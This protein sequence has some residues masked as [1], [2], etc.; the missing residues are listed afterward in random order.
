MNNHL[1]TFQA[2]PRGDVEINP[3]RS[4]FS[5]IVPE[6]SVNLCFDPELLGFGSGA[7]T[8]YDSLGFA[9][10]TAQSTYQRRG[11]F[12]A[13]VT[14]I[15]ERYDGIRYLL[16]LAPAIRTPYT[17]SV[18][19]L[20]IGDYLV[21]VRDTSTTKIVASFQFEG[22]TFWTRQSVTC[23]TQTAGQLALE[24]VVFPDNY[25]LLSYAPGF[26]VDGF[27]FEQKP[28]ATTFISGDVTGFPNERPRGYGWLGTPHNSASYRFVSTRSG[29]K[30]VPFDQMG[31][32]VLEFTGLGMPDPEHGLV[33][34]ALLHGAEYGCTRLP[35][36]EFSI[37]GQLSGA[38]PK[39]W[40]CDRQKMVSAFNPLKGLVRLQFQLFDCQTPL[41]E[42][43]DI[44]ALYQSGMDLRFSSHFGE[45]ISAS[46]VMPKPLIQSG[47]IQSSE[48]SIFDPPLELPGV[49]ARGAN[50]HWQFIL[51][52]DVN[53]P[54]RD[55]VIGPDG[56]LY[57]LFSVDIP[58]QTS[59]QRFDG[60]NWVEIAVIDGDAVRMAA[61][62]N[63]RLYI[64]GEFTGIVGLGIVLDS[65]V[66]YNIRS[67]TF[68]DMNSTT[69][70]GVNV[71]TLRCISYHKAGFLLVGGSFSSIDNTNSAPVSCSNV[72][73]YDIQTSTWSDMGGG[74]TGSSV[75]ALAVADNGL[76]FAGGRFTDGAM[77]NLAR[78]DP[79]TGLW[80]ETD[81][82][83]WDGDPLEATVYALAFAPNGRLYVGGRFND[84]ALH[85]YT[86]NGF[87]SGTPHPIC[88]I[89]YYDATGKTPT[90][91]AGLWP[92]GTGTDEDYTLGVPRE[93]AIYDIAV[94]CDG[95]VFV[96]GEF[97]YVYGPFSERGVPGSPRLTYFSPGLA[98]FSPD[99]RWRAPEVLMD[100]ENDTYV[101]VKAVEFGVNCQNQGNVA[102]FGSG[103]A[104]TSG[105]IGVPPGY[106][107]SL[108]V[109]WADVPGIA[110][111][112][113]LPATTVIN[114]GCSVD[115]R[116]VIRVVGPGSLHAITNYSTGERITF[117]PLI[118]QSEETIT[119]DLESPTPRIYSNVQGNVANYLVD[120]TQLSIFR[121]QP[122]NNYIQL[123]YN[124]L[125]GGV[126]HPDAKVLMSW[127]NLYLSID[128]ACAVECARGL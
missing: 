27:Q 102:I 30:V 121:L 110:P 56:L 66:S 9:M 106:S 98:S 35:S 115:V 88:N 47:G 4:Y 50:G 60:I 20:G 107:G 37:I 64:V 29:G 1:Y 79:D 43:F 65:I 120:T 63:N 122:G 21:R 32:R 123:L 6:E 14:N 99:L 93:S 22:Q 109:G 94:N 18:D 38:Q 7:T 90:G 103:V 83:N 91:R 17:F 78:Y 53:H 87:P 97:R 108:F 80:T 34:Y 67:G 26:Y 105:L 25:A 127:R 101:I 44:D 58:F 125:S 8:G 39:D 70:T 16:P 31:L 36:R 73:I 12:C 62:P 124:T 85:N 23:I 89:A 77:E 54:I 68:E 3:G 40:L 72:A 15:T 19:H 92:V 128:A 111:D 48:V 126:P 104:G 2:I 57:V 82:P 71:P 28:Y 55:M 75:E 33:D 49:V 76:I 86:A 117:R 84:S 11:V 96:A 118:I 46:F 42:V 69:V 100:P 41:S 5:V 113:L 45:R 114:V 10:I 116:P 95:E 61:A 52:S 81:S 24:V 119:I 59:L 13:H 51:G 74:L 112:V